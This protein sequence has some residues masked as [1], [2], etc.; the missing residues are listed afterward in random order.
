VQYSTLPV[1][2]V[3]LG[4]EVGGK[5]GRLSFVG[6]V[7]E[8]LYVATPMGPSFDVDLAYDL[9][10]NKASGSKAPDFTA[11]LGVGRLYRAVDVDGLKSGTQF[12]ELK[13]AQT[14]IKAGVGMSF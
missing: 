12:G 6:G 8:T 11:D 3:G 7:E 2:G 5:F 4:G 10:N 1:P 14:M 13:D 9:T